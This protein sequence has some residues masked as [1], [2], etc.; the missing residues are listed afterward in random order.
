MTRLLDL[1]FAE[2]A[3]LPAAEQDAFAAFMLAELDSEARRARLFEASQDELARL[4][5]EA[6]SDEGTNKA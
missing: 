4:A 2:A 3:K 6:I 1:A 5:R